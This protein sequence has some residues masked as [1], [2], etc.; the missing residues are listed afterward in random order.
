MSPRN[1]ALLAGAAFIGTASL[2]AMAAPTI[3]IHPAMPS[4][5]DEVFVAHYDYDCGATASGQYVRREA[6]PGGL[7][8][9]VPVEGPRIVFMGEY[10]YFCLQSIGVLGAG[11]HE[12]VPV[13]D[14]Y[15]AEYSQPVVDALESTFLTID[16]GKPP[17]EVDMWTHE[18]TTM[19]RLF[20]SEGQPTTLLR[21]SGNRFAALAHETDRD[22]VT[23]FGLA[24]GDFRRMETG[25]PG[26]MRIRALHSDARDNLYAIASQRSPHLAESF[27]IWRMDSVTGTWSQYASWPYGYADPTVAVLRDGSIILLKRDSTTGYFRLYKFTPAGGWLQLAGTITQGVFGFVRDIAD[28]VYL[29]LAEGTGRQIAFTIAAVS[30]DT[31]E[32]LSLATIPGSSYPADWFPIGLQ[33]SEAGNLFLIG[34][35]AGYTLDRVDPV[36][37]R[38]DQVAP[39]RTFYPSALGADGSYFFSDSWYGVLRYKAI[40][41]PAVPVPS[42]G[43]GP[44]PVCGELRLD[45]PNSPG[46]YP[47]C[48]DKNYMQLSYDQ[49]RVGALE[50]DLA[51]IV[52]SVQSSGATLALMRRA[53]GGGSATQYIDLTPAFWVN[54]SGMYQAKPM[55]LVA[56]PDRA[57]LYL[58]AYQMV[59]GDGFSSRVIEI[60][61]AAASAKAVGTPSVLATDLAIAPSGDLYLTTRFGEILRRKA[62]TAAWATFGRLSTEHVDLHVAADAAERIYVY[63]SHGVM[64]QQG[65]VAKVE[66]FFHPRLGHYFM[67]GNRA[68]GA[69]LRE[70]AALGWMPTGESFPA[71]GGLP[72]SNASAQPRDVCRF[73]GSLNPGPNTHFYT[74]VPSECAGLKALQ[75]ST[76]VTEPRWNYEGTAFLSLLGSAGG[77]CPATEQMVVRFF[78]GGSA[79]GL[80]PN[81][82]YVQGA[83]LK[84]QMN[85]AG[86]IAEDSAFC[87]P[88]ESFT[89]TFAR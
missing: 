49:P 51:G 84:A 83:G 23:I 77:N 56:T 39:Q 36:N 75:Q 55:R 14:A 86:W 7:R 65:T 81:H 30:T 10:P 59:I 19:S 4:E 31:G 41:S 15:D 63:G 2:T 11:R 44:R 34:R 24:P 47:Y 71:I 6:I 76:P 40:G 73:Y 46:P 32:F 3:A 38:L 43:L 53:A 29:T 18:P 88:N 13:A 62:G 74:G 1:I 89:R 54:P 42:G 87:V 52:Y 8:I 5:T 60:D 79:K 35:Y 28:N 72:W 82:R 48:D 12:I 80:V 67:T 85:A 37:G 45:A 78:N 64:W 25:F 58:L 16:P 57:K 69:S 66:E 9:K 50:Q 33:S 61:L 17:P 21:L 26:P 68:E 70:N 22:I 27:A 20:V